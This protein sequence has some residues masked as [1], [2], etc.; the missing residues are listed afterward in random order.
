MLPPPLT[1]WSSL[2]SQ[3]LESSCPF[4][5]LGEAK[6]KVSSK[7]QCQNSKARSARCQ[8][9]NSSLHAGLSE[10]SSLLSRSAL[11][12]DKLPGDSHVQES[13]RSTDR[14]DLVVSSKLSDASW[15][16]GVTQQWSTLGFRGDGDRKGLWRKAARTPQG[17]KQGGWL[18]I[19]PA[20]A[21]NQLDQ[22]SSLAF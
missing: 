13:L 9:L 21:D 22:G 17:K 15:A 18:R 2:S 20:W 11:H 6:L 8:R 16:S 5:R 7:E 1:V 19:P 14:N 12:L 4:C 3:G 10:Q